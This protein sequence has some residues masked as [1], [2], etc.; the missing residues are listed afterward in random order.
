[1]YRHIYPTYK[2]YRNTVRRQLYKP[3]WTEEVR[4][5]KLFR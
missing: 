5:I 3:I 1:M 2:M 4:L